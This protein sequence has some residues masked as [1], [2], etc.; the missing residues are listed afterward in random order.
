M[1]TN[2]KPSEPAPLD[3]S[4]KGLLRGEVISLNR[5]LFMKFTAYGGCHDPA[6]VIAALDAAGV[7]GA[8]Y[9][10]ANDPQGIGIMAASEDPDYFVTTLRDL[11]NGPA[12]AAL[13]HKPEFDMLGRSYSIGYEPSLED[14]LLEKPM[15]K[16]LNPAWPW[17]IWYPLQRAKKFQTLSEDHQR[18]ILAEHGTLAKRY[19]IGGH[20]ADVRLAC[21]GLDKND[22]DFIV[23][24]IGPKLHPLSAVV[25]EMRKTEQTSQYLDSLGPFF[26]GRAAWQSAYKPVS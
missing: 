18:R 4:E 20:A 11:F 16:L 8:L 23:G 17:A 14:T 6:P 21:H 15:Q 9:L 10:D 24:L 19:G 13:T 1:S 22:N 2:A 7:V 26:I 5:R 25:Q 3:L 12:F